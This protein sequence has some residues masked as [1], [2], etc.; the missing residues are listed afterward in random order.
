MVPLEYPDGVA[1]ARVPWLFAVGDVR[2][3]AVRVG[4]ELLAASVV[5]VKRD[6]RMFDP[7]RPGNV[8]LA[9]FAV[10]VFHEPVPT[11]DVVGAVRVGCV[12]CRVVAIGLPRR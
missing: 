1:V 4:N 9:G 11:V 2:G 10:R 8:L 7:V 5:C 12:G 6:S 3:R